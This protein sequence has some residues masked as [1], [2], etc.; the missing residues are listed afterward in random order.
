MFNQDNE[1]RRNTQKEYVEPEKVLV[2]HS[3]KLGI[4]LTGPW[5]IQQTD[6][7]A[8][9]ALRSQNASLS[10]Q[11]EIM[12]AQMKDLIEAMKAREVPFALRTAAEKVEISNRGDESQSI[13]V[14]DESPASEDH[15]KLILEFSKLSKDRFG[16]W[17]MVNLDRLQSDDYPPAV[18]S[19]V[20]EKW[21]RMIKGDFPLPA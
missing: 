19:M 21:G 2:D 1:R 12:Q 8:V 3:D 7:A 15:T 4:K 18:L 5:T 11:I 10:T 20:R 6:N 9:E 17:V 13:T 16:E 14:S